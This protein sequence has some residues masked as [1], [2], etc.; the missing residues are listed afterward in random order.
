M[1]IQG[2]NLLERSFLEQKQINKLLGDQRTLRIGNII[3]FTCETDIDNIKADQ[4]INFYCEIPDISN[5]A[6]VCFQQLFIANIA[7]ILAKSYFDAPIEIINN[8]III[9]KEH[10]NQGIN[11]LDGIAS[12]TR[13]K[14]LQDTI[15]IYVGLYNTIEKRTSIPRAFALNLPQDKYNKFMDEVNG[16]FYTLA[17][18][19]FL[20][21]VKM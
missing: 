18:N 9:K 13:I 15:I 19:I 20:Q 10:K 7:N 17:N 3:S 8:E 11:Q 21:T 1:I 2:Y 14:R 12:A 6:G 5:Y 4:M 16:N